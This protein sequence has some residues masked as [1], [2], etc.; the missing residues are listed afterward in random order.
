[1]L[2]CTAAPARALAQPIT[3]VAEEDAG[4]ALDLERLRAALELEL[5]RPV[6]VG[7]QGPARLV[8]RVADDGAIELRYEAAEARRSRRI[9]LHV[10]EPEPARVVML[11]ASNLVRDQDVE[12]AREIEVRPPEEPR[13]PADRSPPREPVSAPPE[14]VAR[15]WRVG[16]GASVGL[17]LVHGPPAILLAPQDATAGSPVLYLVGASL[18]Y[19]VAPVLA[20]GIADVTFGVAR[21]AGGDSG[22]AGGS[23]F[24]EIFFSIDPRVQIFGDAGLAIQGRFG[25]ERARGAG[26]AGTAH[27][28]VRFFPLDAMS[29]AASVG[30]HVVLT[31]AFALGERLLPQWSVA[32]HAGVQVGWHFD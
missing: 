25:H 9:R 2:L 24:A 30:G 11:V 18:S 8:L 12:I 28:G 1:L 6:V 17:T 23:P 29:L 26:L 16:I 27:L 3:I 31:D 19:T 4:G 32:G 10:Y 14:T 5:G 20:I 22:F 15:S 7:G 13:A 21:L